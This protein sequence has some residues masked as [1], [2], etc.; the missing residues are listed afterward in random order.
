MNGLRSTA[1]RRCGVEK[2]ED[3][4]EERCKRRGKGRKLSQGSSLS[5]FSEQEVDKFQS[6][7]TIA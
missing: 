7:F 5:E 1:R 4:A 6:Y 2:V 3:C